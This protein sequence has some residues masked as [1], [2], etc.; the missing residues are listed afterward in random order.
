MVQVI[1]GE[2]NT[3]LPLPEG[4]GMQR[5]PSPLTP[6]LDPSSWDL[7]PAHIISFSTEVYFFLHYGRHLVERA[8]FLA[9]E[10]ISR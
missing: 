7:G 9:G 8:S 3:G 1:W 2:Q 6:A 5:R 10:R 4:W